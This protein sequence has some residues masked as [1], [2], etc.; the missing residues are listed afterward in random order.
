M[1]GSAFLRWNVLL[2]VTLIL[3]GHTWSEVASAETINVASLNH[4]TGLYASWGEHQTVA[5]ALAVEEINS[6]DKFK[7]AG[8]KL[9]AIQY[10]DASVPANAPL[11]VRKAIID[12]HCLILV[13]PIVSTCVL[14]NMPVVEKLGRPWVITSVVDKITEMGIPGFFGLSARTRLVCVSRQILLELS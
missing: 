7:Q 5:V 6:W 13:G 2:V 3:L 4:V 1:R 10:D 12:D 14:S 11:M 9:N 8:Y